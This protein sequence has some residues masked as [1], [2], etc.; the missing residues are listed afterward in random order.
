MRTLSVASFL[1]VMSIVPLSASTLAAEPYNVVILISDDQRAD[2]VT[3]EYMPNV[4]SRLVVGG[5][6]FPNAFVPNSLCC[7]S[8]ASVLTGNHSHTTGV[9]TNHS[10]EQGGFGAFDDSSTIAT[11]FETAGYRT[12]LIG[13]YLNDYE[14]ASLYMPPGWDR[15]FA[16]AGST[17]YYNYTANSNDRLVSFGSDPE[18]YVA[19]VTVRRAIRFVERSAAAPFFL[20]YS[21]AAPHKPAQ[22]APRDGSRFAGETDSRVHDNMLEAAYSMDRSIGRLLDVLPGHTIVAYLSDNGYLW[23]EVK[24]G[25]GRLTAKEWPYDGSIRIPFVIKALDSRLPLDTARLALNIDLRETLEAAVGLEPPA[26]DGVDLQ[27]ESRTVF[28]L[29]HLVNSVKPHI[30]SYCGA[31][32]RD[33]MYVRYEGGRE[34]LFREPNERTNLADDPTYAETLDRLKGS[35]IDLCDPAPPGYGWALG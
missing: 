27:M 17:Q 34:E 8:R 25:H 2:N 26:T 9:W 7:P 32:E 20:Y 13:K 29:E 31:R 35:A 3:P 5:A 12:A 16:L 23:G 21:F 19:H 18:D 6:W 24:S 11:D 22:P 10:D 30:E 14:P 1:G 4:W 28:P 15:W 33:W